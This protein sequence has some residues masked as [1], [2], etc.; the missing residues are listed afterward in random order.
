MLDAG[1][2]QHLISETETAARR[3]RVNAKDGCRWCEGRT[4]S[5]RVYS[6]L[7]VRSYG[8]TSES[9]AISNSV[10]HP[11]N[12]SDSRENDENMVLTGMSFRRVS[13]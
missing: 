4:E 1:D 7:C 5:C 11:R 9:V 10:S 12:F 13:M 2:E 6:L 3:L 8:A